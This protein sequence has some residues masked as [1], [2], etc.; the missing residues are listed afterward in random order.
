MTPCF[1]RPEF[2]SLDLS[3][4]LFLLFDMPRLRPDSI[5]TQPRLPLPLDLDDN[6]TTSRHVYVCA[7]GI[8]GHLPVISSPAEVVVPLPSTH[9]DD[10]VLQ[11]MLGNMRE[12][13]SLK[14]PNCHGHIEQISDALFFPHPLPH[15]FLPVSSSTQP[16]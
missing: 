6:L 16:Q 7:R 14:P 4:S 5:S 9:N 12:S 3:I 11:T 15:M 1:P 8:V 10:A 13:V 2:V